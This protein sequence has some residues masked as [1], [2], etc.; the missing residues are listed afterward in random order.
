MAAQP[1][2]P[3]LLAFR[4]P[5]FRRYWAGQLAANVAAWVAIVATGWLVLELT[6][7]PVALGLNAGLQALPLLVCTLIGGVIADRF[8]RYHLIVAV[9]ALLVLTDTAMAVLVGSGNVRIEHIYVYSV[10]GNG[11]GAL[12]SPARQS[13]VPALVPATALLSAVSLSSVLWHGSAVLGPAVAGVV[14]VG[15]G[16]PAN[17]YLNAAGQLIGLVSLLAIRG[18]VPPTAAPTISPWHSLAEG[19]RYAWAQPTVRAVL[20]LMTGV[21]MVGRSYPHVMPI[22]ARDVYDAGPQGL[23]IMLTMTAVGTILAGFG[24]GAAQNVPLTRAFVV[25]TAAM[26]LALLWFAASPLFWLALAPLVLMGAT[27]QGV[28]A[29]GSTILQ[30]TVDD[31]RRGRVMSFYT[32]C[33]WGGAR[34]GALP[35]AFLA[36][37]VG[38]PQAVALGAIV[39]LLALVPLVR[40]NVLRQWAPGPAT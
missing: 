24:L 11:L 22:F 10:V 4:S 32:A 38:A 40:S 7:S 28:T 29:M 6:G 16:I 13:I 34:I 31:E 33:T 5:M 15:W 36:E 37:Q 35:T 2:G 12:S 18:A 20:L 8:N 23:G 14:M 25:G 26:G 21:S 3:T 39:L 27:V 30:Q 9:Q 1:A 19:L 17:F